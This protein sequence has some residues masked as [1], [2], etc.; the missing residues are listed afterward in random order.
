MQV[1]I[2][3]KQKNS[4]KVL[5]ARVKLLGNLLGNV[6]RD[7][8]GESVFNAVETL[9]K[10]YINLRK[11]DSAKTQAKVNDLVESLD[12]ATATHVVRAFSI[13]FNL[14]SL[15]EEEY[16][17]I[18]RRKTVKS[19]AP[20]WTGS[21]DDTIRNFQQQGVKAEQLE[22][23]LNGLA[24]IPVITAHPTEAKRRTTLETQR[25]IFVMIKELDDPRLNQFQRD[26]AVN[27]IE[28]GIRQLWMTDEVR[29]TR[30]QV[31]D[32]IK[33]GLYYFK[34][35]LF[36]AIPQSYRHLENALKRHYGNDVVG[37]NI[38]IPGIIK[39][40]SWIGGDRDGN[41]NVKPET[42]EMALRMQAR[43]VLSEYLP[44][45]Q[46]LIHHLTHS[47]SLCSF[48]DPLLSSLAADEG[49]YA[50]STFTIKAERFITEPYRRKLDIMCYRLNCNLTA[51]EARLA[52]KDASESTIDRY[53]SE[54]EF[55][56]DLNIISDSL[57]NNGDQA[58]ADAQ[59]K[60][61]IRLVETFG[62]Y[63]LKLDIRQES[64]R[65]SAAV[66]E[67]LKDKFDYNA[68]S[69]DERLE[70]L[71]KLIAE[72]GR[73]SISDLNLADYS[74]DTQ[75]TL[76]V[77]EVMQNM[78]KE[79]SPDAFGAYVISMTHEASHIMEVMFLANLAGMAGYENGK[80]FCELQIGP[81][82]ETIEDLKH[83]EPVMTKLLNN[84]A[85]GE[86]LKVSGNL[87]EVMLGYSDSCK[88][89]GILSS[90]WSLYEAQKQITALAA[91]RGIQI[92]L[93]HGR[94]GTVGRGG[95]PT[96]EAILSQPNG[97]VGG[98][99]KFTEQG[100]VLSSKYS[101]VE[102]A[103]Y[104][105]TMGVTG[106][107]KASRS[108]IETPANDNDE[109]LEIM[110][111]IAA[112]GE[113]TYRELTDRTP[114]FLDYFY[115]ATPLS[116]IALMNIGSRPSH[117]KKG[118]RS[119]GSVRAIAWVFGWS[120]SRQTLPAWLGIGSAL[121]NWM[122]GDEKRAAKLNEMYQ[123]WPFFRALMSNTQMAL[124]KSDAN[125]A[126]KYSELC[127]DPATGE[128]IYALIR[129]E[130]QL[131]T[132]SILKVTNSKKLMEENPFLA[133]S[134]SR[135]NPYLDPLNSIQV[136]L[137]KRYRDESRSDE[138]REVWLSPLLRSINAIAAG[139]RNTG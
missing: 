81:L 130:L 37:K 97:T 18:Q 19:A 116:E 5:R 67:V 114:G 32:E 87:Q 53:P 133:L 84:E 111:E 90:A 22:T 43:Q 69:E 13:Y 127:V 61:L 139:M 20:L 129:D 38:K 64:T 100:E 42:T 59:L 108:L 106:L 134:L 31:A 138:E 2:M 102:T 56:A 44:R 17:H 27:K 15:A 119:K 121:D 51:V 1:V 50:E 110:G 65:H 92:R 99:I 4:D 3:A 94:G 35:S 80:A 125:I 14:V 62:F 120:Q 98:E 26:D 16:Q 10:G 89:G 77:V 49:Q 82:F 30:P 112:K 63:L 48:S 115:E 91:A 21:F 23:L 123:N 24:Y 113:D 118:D 57:I 103:V 58:L 74:D 109:Y 136:T 86:L 104:E 28:M 60:D 12:P 52:G 33:N 137:I 107:M 7:Q 78:R 54:K 88:D 40:G 11:K 83:I 46:E 95:G 124:F 25:R 126:K 68:L 117:R 131:T 71:S 79:I 105:L 9:R 132:D 75:E 47:K 41:P 36:D 73:K 70:A 8:A 66:A 85:Y 55:L 29:S 34:E 39:F 128:N 135:R 122:Q 93:F 101:N 96:H 76:R 6:I 72:D 45:T